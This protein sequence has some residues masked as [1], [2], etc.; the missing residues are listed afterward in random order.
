MKNMKNFC[1]SNTLVSLN[2]RGLRNPK[3]RNAIFAYLKNQKATIFYFQE[4]FSKQDEVVW[5]LDWGSQII[6]SHGTE[7]SRQV[8][9]RF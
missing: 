7:N 2:V 5:S 6:F 3:K 4:T 1:P 8:C 9:V